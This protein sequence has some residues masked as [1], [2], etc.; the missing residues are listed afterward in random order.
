ME[1]STWLLLDGR[2][3]GPPVIPLL[4]KTPR[5]RRSRMQLELYGTGRQLHHHSVWVLQT[6]RRLEPQLFRM[7]PQAR[8]GM[9]TRR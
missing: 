5:T 3:A 6:V 9:A 4:D 7:P 8:D 1:C 2:A